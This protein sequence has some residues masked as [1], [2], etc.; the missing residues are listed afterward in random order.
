DLPTKALHVVGNICSAGSIG[1]CSDVRFKNDIEPLD[2][3]LPP[4]DRLTGVRYSWRVEDFAEIHFGTDRQVG[5]VAQEV[6]KVLPE[7]VTEQSDGSLTVDYSRLTP[8]LI[9]AIKELRS[10]NESLKE[11]VEAPERT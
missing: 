11:R 2:G 7:A 9:Q 5:L 8:V 4:V 3:A 1:A 10:E 6:R